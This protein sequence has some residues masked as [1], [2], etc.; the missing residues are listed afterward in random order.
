MVVVVVLIVLVLMEMGLVVLVVVVLVD[1]VVLE[2]KEQP[3]TPQDDSEATLLVYSDWLI[4]EGREQESQ[5]VRETLTKPQRQWEWQW[6]RVV[7]GGVTKGRC[8]NG[9][10]RVHMVN[11]TPTNTTED[12]PLVCETSVGLHPQSSCV[13]VFRVVYMQMRTF[14]NHLNRLW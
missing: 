6:R 3:V 14:A 1:L 9:F 10:V 12:C 8:L 4:D 5:W 2:D 13:L 11:D 7:V